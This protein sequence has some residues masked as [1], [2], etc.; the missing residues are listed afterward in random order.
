M[1]EF[2]YEDSLFVIRQKNPELAEEI[3]T[4]VETLTKYKDMGTAG[5]IG[6]FKKFARKQAGQY[7]IEFYHEQYDDKQQTAE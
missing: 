4:T 2:E 6:E 7:L 1:K 5:V 3:K